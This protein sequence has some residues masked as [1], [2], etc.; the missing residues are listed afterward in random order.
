MRAV[1]KEIFVAIVIFFL[2]MAFSYTEAPRILRAPV[3]VYTESVPGYS[4]ENA[5]KEAPEKKIPTKELREMARFIMGG[6]VYGWKFTYTPSDKTRNV[7]E[8]FLLEPIMEIPDN[9]PKFSLTGIDSRYPRLSC[10]AEFLLDDSIAHR[11]D[12][13]NSVQFKAAN[14]K[15]CGERI[16]EVAGIKN[17][18]T[19]AVLQ[20]IRERE[21]K[22]EKNKPKELRGEVLLKDSPRLY[23]DQGQFVAEIRVLINI[24]E[25]VPYST[26]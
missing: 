26:F 10:W 9:D 2:C 14:G 6:M 5:Q 4:A 20:A 8:Y 12:Y 18:Y 16:D 7:Q 17:A 23:A 1:S 21:R 22:I 24:L 15:G 19:K 25:I 11:S 3:W 13:W